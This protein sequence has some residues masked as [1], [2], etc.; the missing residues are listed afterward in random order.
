[1]PSVPVSVLLVLLL[2]TCTAA[3]E[4]RRLPSAAAFQ[5]LRL[6]RMREMKETILEREEEENRNPEEMIKS[7]E[8]E[9]VT[10][11]RNSSSS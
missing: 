7:V 11:T 5:L 6:E 3:G 9:K 4:P 8:M 10:V 2:Q 1:M